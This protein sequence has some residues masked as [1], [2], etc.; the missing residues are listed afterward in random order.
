MGLLSRIFGFNRS[1]SSADTKISANYPDEYKQI[2]KFSDSLNS[3]LGKD[4]FIARSD[5]DGLV[6]EYSPLPPFIDTLKKSKMLKTYIESNNLDLN[7]IERFSETYRKLADVTNVPDFIKKHNDNFVQRHLKGEK[8][9]LDDILKECDPNIMLDDEQREVV[10]SNEDYTLVIAGAG[11]GKTTTVAA[12]VRYL[13][14]K[15]GVNPEQILVISFTNKA[16]NELK[17]RIN[18]NLKI[19]CPISTFHSIGNS[20]MNINEDGKKRIVEGGYMF[21]VINRYLKENVLRDSELVDKLIL[22]F[23]SYFTANTSLKI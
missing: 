9:Y 18:H 13:V 23:G 14:E 10:L 20:I 7:V 22:F 1:D 4:R 11:A 8:K 16:V 12:K 5:Y 19:N 21:S 6:K 15:Q 3:I 2:L 17:E